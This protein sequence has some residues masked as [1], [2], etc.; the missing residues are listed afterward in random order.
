M[1]A[2]WITTFSPWTWYW[3]K[4]RSQP[5]SSK[6]QGWNKLLVWCESLPVHLVYLCN[7]QC[8]T[9]TILASLGGLH[10]SASFLLRRLRRLPFSQ[11]GGIPMSE[12]E[13]CWWHTNRVPN[14]MISKWL[15]QIKWFIWFIARA[16]VPTMNDHIQSFSSQPL[17]SCPWLP[18]QVT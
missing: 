5:F 9:V 4:H 15:P 6:L 14:N 12:R 13:T 8:G 7:H 16:S 2:G 11:V 18:N 17:I 10:M 1:V 3:A